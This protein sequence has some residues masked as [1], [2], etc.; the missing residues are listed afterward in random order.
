LRRHYLNAWQYRP[1]LI[2]DST[3][4]LSCRLRPNLGGTGNKNKN[5]C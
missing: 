3:A 1:A 5:A 4:D 2:S